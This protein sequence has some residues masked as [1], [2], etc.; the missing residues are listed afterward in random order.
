MIWRYGIKLYTIQDILCILFVRKL[1]NK[2]IGVLNAKEYFRL[3]DKSRSS[4]MKYDSKSAIFVL[5]HSKSR[6]AV[7]KYEKEEM[8]YGSSAG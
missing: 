1:L 8:F 6:R 7:S 4:V 2:I 3:E 5:G